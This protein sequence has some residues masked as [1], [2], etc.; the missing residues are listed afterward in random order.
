[1][2]NL[3]LTYFKTFVEGIH[4]ESNAT[5][6]DKILYY[7]ML[8][9]K[10]ILVDKSAIKYLTTNNVQLLR[11]TFGFEVEAL[12]A[13]FYSTFEE[14][15]NSSEFEL[16]VSQLLNYVTVYGREDAKPFIP[17]NFE[18]K[19]LKQ[20][21]K[22]FV[23][24]S[25]TTKEEFKSRVEKLVSSGMALPNYVIYPLMEL[26]ENLGIDINIIENRELLI[27]YS[28]TYKKP[29][30]DPDLFF[31]TL[32]SFMTHSNTYINNKITRYAIEYSQ[33]VDSAAEYLQAYKVSYSLNDLVPHVR[34][35][36]KS[37]LI[38]RKALKANKNY[39][40]KAVS[41]INYLLR[42][43]KENNIPKKFPISSKMT[44]TNFE[45]KDLESYVKDANVYS[46]V[47]YINSIKEKLNRIINGSEGNVYQI[48]NG[49]TFVKK[50]LETQRDLASGVTQDNIVI[51]TER[52]TII[53]NELYSRYKDK[54]NGKKI[55]MSDHPLQL[56]MPTSGKAFI[57]SIPVNSYLP[58]EDDYT[59]GIYWTGKPYEHIDIDLHF[60]TQN[61]TIGWNSSFRSNKYI[62][63]MDMTSLNES[64]NAAEF[65][66]IK[67]ADE[68]FIG[69]LTVSGYYLRNTQPYTIVVANYLKGSM[70]DPNEIILGL[71]TEIEECDN[72]NI[73]YLLGDPEKDLIVFSNNQMQLGRVP[74]VKLNEI[75]RE[76][77]VNK[78]TSQLTLETFLN[79][80]NAQI[81]I[82]PSELEEDDEFIDLR[83]ETLT[84]DSF[85][86]LLEFD[87]E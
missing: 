19:D 5:L 14:I 77:I 39:D 31:K 37:L 28:R 74:D 41:S 3:T 53:E 8:L 35:Y 27:L 73:A 68:K 47:R 36:K 20:L 30:K 18:E 71:K 13:T 67:K 48:R 42:K 72:Q 46:L 65:I 56:V 32:F 79:N 66:K 22:Q 81:I 76:A 57:G 83:L 64:G 40:Y 24:I 10:G 7:K 58:I 17:S 84:Q 80:V 82:D 1:M 29:M 63:S 60:A 2:K 38:F 9:N 61:T 21:S 4:E 69:N 78:V 86:S 16:I 11:K 87:E 6:E 33:C 85:T 59:V 43:N 75:A 34:R 25:A 62:H 70:I 26:I 23:I 49:K 50:T 12:S 44:D 55:L 54:F 52:L 45:I 15:E 51:L